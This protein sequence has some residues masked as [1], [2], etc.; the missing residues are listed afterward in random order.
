MTLNRELCDIAQKWA[1]H[2]AAE[3]AMEHS[4]PE[5][6][7]CSKGETGENLYYNEST[8]ELEID[9]APAVESWYN[10]IKDY[11]FAKPDFSMKTG[12]IN[13]ADWFSKDF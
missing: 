1:D 12:M 8:G 3:N 2:L 5:Q 6:R 4:S 11:D 13:P 7:R 9:G 10:E